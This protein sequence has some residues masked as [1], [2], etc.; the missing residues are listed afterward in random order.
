MNNMKNT[1]S[2]VLIMLFTV[3]IYAQGINY[4]AVIKDDT[5]GVVVTQTIKV[6]F[7]ILQGAGMTNVYQETHTPTTDA[8]GII[9]IN[10]G[11]GT[12]NVVGDFTAIDWGI[13]SHFLNT[14]IEIVSGAGLI[15]I[16]TTAFMAV[17]YALHASNGLPAG[18]TVGQILKIDAN[19]IAVWVDKN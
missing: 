9:V 2:I 4:K 10:I 17:P 18:G 8:N 12:T 6:Q 19:G 13:D 5:G 14:Q 15:N 11:E 16:D 1:L 7:Q 3:T